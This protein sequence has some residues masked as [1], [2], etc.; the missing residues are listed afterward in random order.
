MLCKDK[1]LRKFQAYLH[2]IL[3]NFQIIL[4]NYIYF[5]YLLKII[6]RTLRNIL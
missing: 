5:D 3:R 4:N 2:Y 1:N 6:V